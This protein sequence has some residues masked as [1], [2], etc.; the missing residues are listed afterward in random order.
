MKQII[1]TIVL[2]A[3]VV[4]LVVGVIIPITNT[5][6]EAGDKSFN[7]VKGLSDTIKE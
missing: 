3:L 7:S 6:E 5:T 4:G 1:V 2:L